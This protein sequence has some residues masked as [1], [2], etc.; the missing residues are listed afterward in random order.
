M[1]DSVYLSVIIPV[2]NE[3]RR[4]GKTLQA[5]LAFLKKQPYASEIIVSDDGSR[6]QTLAIARKELEDY[7]HQILEVD[8]NYG[9][10]HAVKQGMLAGRG[11]FLLFS[12]A[13]MSTPID[14]VTRFLTKMV[15]GKYDC[16]IGSRGMAASQ[17][18]IHQNVFR[19]FIGRVFNRIARLLS[20]KQIADSQCGF[21]CFSRTAAKEL[22]SLQKING[23][24]FDAE[25]LYL[26]Q[27][28]GYYLL[29]EPVIWRD[30][31]NS[32]VR[33]LS[34]P[35]KMFWDLLKIRLYHG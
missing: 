14:E 8:K 26:A 11:Q 10:G 18:E 7:P 35:I 25:I 27:K 32:R 23:F 21:K 30:D 3:E 13:D 20:F 24:S 5:M 2:Y 12:D 29:E 17:I 28:K 34:D 1:P 16:V 9:K 31:K 6:D 4:L 33:L 19:E 22:F 15:Q